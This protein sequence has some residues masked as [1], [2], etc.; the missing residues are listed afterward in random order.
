[1]SSVFSNLTILEFRPGEFS[2]LPQNDHSDDHFVIHTCQRSVLLSLSRHVHP[3]AH[4]AFHGIDAYHYFLRFACG[5][6]SKIQGETD[7]FGQVKI[8]FKKLQEENAELAEQFRGFF[9]CWLEDT[10]EIRAQ[11]LQNVGGNNYG[12]LARRLLNPKVGDSVVVLGAG[13]VSKTVAP[14]FAEFELKVW[15]RSPERL[16]DLAHQLSRKGNKF[17]AL[18]DHKS[19]AAA[20]AQATIVIFATPADV[21]LPTDAMAAIS[22]GARILHLGAQRDQVQ[23]LAAVLDNQ[24]LTLTDLFE[25]DQEQALVRQKQ[26]RQALDA[27]HQRSLLR[28][29]ARS[30]HIA[31]GWEDLALFY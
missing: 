19:L 13:L 23:S 16:I 31:H 10:K 1:M 22:S 5:L 30:I 28:N 4:R 11:F 18:V 17:Q 27:C 24:L 20:V 21:A 6:E 7:V 9:A 26:V 14:Y 25:I 8:A 2:D 3:L 12:A 15:N 29:L